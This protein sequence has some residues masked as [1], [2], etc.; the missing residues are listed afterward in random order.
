MDNVCRKLRYFGKHAAGQALPAQNEAKPDL[1]IVEVRVERVDIKADIKQ[2][3]LEVKAP[4]TL[5]VV[6]TTEVTG[7]TDSAEQ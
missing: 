4:K 6:E 2:L 5:L 3:T 7:N 1:S